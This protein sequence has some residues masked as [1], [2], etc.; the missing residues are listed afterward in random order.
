MITN[1][2]KYF[3]SSVKRGVFVF[4]VGC[5][6]L[7]VLMDVLLFVSK[8]K[9]YYAS[10]EGAFWF[11]FRSMGYLFEWPRVHLSDYQYHLALVAL[12]SLVVAV[13]CFLFVFY[14]PENWIG[15][16]FSPVKRI[17]VWVRTGR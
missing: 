2:S 6:F 10:T 5:G 8:L 7:Y 11:V 16:A 12:I 13:G 9:S 3:Y 15:K 14:R 1:F 4:G 17:I